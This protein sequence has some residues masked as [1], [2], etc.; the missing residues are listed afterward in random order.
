MNN[1]SYYVEVYNN[2]VRDKETRGAY[3]RIDEQDTQVSLSY[4]AILRH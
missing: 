1:Q 2:I 4:S 3:Q